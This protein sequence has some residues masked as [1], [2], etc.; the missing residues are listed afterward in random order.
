[1]DCT[2]ESR[3]EIWSLDLEFDLSYQV[4]CESHVCVNFFTYMDGFSLGLNFH[5]MPVKIS[6]RSGVL[7][8]PK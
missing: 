3:F 5:V 2:D 1:M 6:S 7:A 8:L 4:C